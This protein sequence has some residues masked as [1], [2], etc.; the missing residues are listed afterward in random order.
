M[1]SY[2][3]NRILILFLFSGL[4]AF[5][6]FSQKTDKK[7]YPKAKNWVVKKVS[8]KI[9]IDGVINEKAWKEAVKTGIEYEWTPG[10]ATPAPVKSEVMVTFDR[11]N[12]YVAFICYDPEPKKIRAHLM[13]RDS[14]NTFIQDDNVSFMI[15]TFNDERRGFQFR[16]NPLGV[17]AD[18]IFSE[19]EGYEDFSWDVIWESAGKITD[20]GYV[21]EVAI[22][23]NQLRFP[24]GSSVQTWGFEASRSWPR[25][26]RHRMST[27]TRD[28]NNMSLLGQFNKITGFKDMSPGKNLEFDPTLTVNRT[29]IRSDFPDGEL[30]NGKID[31]DPGISARWGI[32]SNLVLNAAINPDFSQVEAD[33]AQLEVNT[34][35][36]LKYAEKRP[37]FLEGADFFLTPLEAVFTRTVYSPYW[38][39]KLTGK[40]GKSA[41]GV[42][43]TRDRVNNLIFPS[44][45]GSQSI[46]LSDP[47]LGGVFRYRHDIGKGSALGLLYTGRFGD[48]YENH[49]AGFD[50]FFRISKVKTFTVQ[51]LRSETDY[52]DDLALKYSQDI[53]T[54]GGD[55]L[56]AQLQHFSRN[57]F[58]FLEYEDLSKGFRADSGFIPRVDLRRIEG[59]VHPIIWGKK[60]DWFDRLGFML[61]AEHISDH[62][63]LTTD[64]QLQLV[65]E[66][67]GFLQSVVQPAFDISKEYYNGVTYSKKRFQIYSEIKPA[68]GVNF[69][70]FSQ[71]GNSID[72]TNN[73]LADRFMIMPS[74]ELG[75]GRHLN[76]N[77]SH[78]YERLS[79]EGNKIYN[80]NLLQ[81]KLVYN[82]N[83]RTFM[84]AIV[85]YMDLSRNPDMYM[86]TVTDKT[87]T[88][89][90]QFLFSYKINPQT[91]LFLGY[92][93]NN[94]GMR[95]IDLTKTGRTFFLKIG[96]ALTM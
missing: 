11:K 94:F 47:V 22:P 70:V 16:I 84:R 77:V 21:V 20:F 92:S 33:V 31:I 74:I 67:R 46:S 59:A 79:S 68:G 2:S 14:I 57:M 61:R 26:V 39:G 72:Y 90:T 8:S 69:S 66:Y 43:G 63:G 64:Q 34:R 73:R 35:F 27:H 49:V 93:D 87:R 42:F 6:L 5:N 75:L 96:Y 18:A 44:N 45:Q 32:T 71:L 60:G 52:P 1:K 36:A 91:V 76:L 56:Y 51:Y 81:T 7:I 13:D 78:I 89:F 15:D 24:K 3:I 53:D 40:I 41:L 80:A 12:F 23:F 54:F 10:D 95:G 29:D 58:W 48:N 65:A 86:E 30:E 25:N 55:A 62:N 4:I 85:Q 19:M 83:I 37:F 88:L 17:Q 50:G 9:H 28:R 38:G 82:I